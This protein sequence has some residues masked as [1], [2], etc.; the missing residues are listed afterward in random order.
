MKEIINRLLQLIDKYLEVLLEILTED[1]S[2]VS[3]A[4]L[5]LAV[6]LNILFFVIGLLLS[7]YF[8]IYVLS[9]IAKGAIAFLGGMGGKRWV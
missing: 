1:M 9:I 6:A 2:P 4:L 8:F 7:I 3:K 5:I